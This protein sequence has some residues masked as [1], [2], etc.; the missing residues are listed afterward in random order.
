[1]APPEG[2][3]R[4]YGGAPEVFAAFVAAEDP[5][6]RVK[7]A[8]GGL[9]AFAGDRVLDLGCGTGH[10][11]A[12]LLGQGAEVVAV[13]RE[14]ALLARAPSGPAYVRAD[15]RRLPLRDSTVDQVLAAWVVLNSPPA[16]R[17][18]LLAE[19]ARVLR[20]GGATWLVENH[21]SGAFH[22]LRGEP[23]E[24]VERLDEL[25]SV[26]GFREAEVVDT[27]LCFPDAAEAARILGCLLGPEAAARLGGRSRLPHRVVILERPT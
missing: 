20:P 24:E 15:G 3:T 9:R 27:E 26:H 21:P 4:A 19:S 5:E 14:A 10:V 2:W 1:M 23:A 25:K 7:A 6:G 18:A 11:S 16:A 22:A 8:L 12:W 17:R 13:D